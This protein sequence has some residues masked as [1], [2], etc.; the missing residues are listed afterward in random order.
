MVQEWN[1]GT[2]TFNRS[3]LI[4]LLLRVFVQIEF[5]ALH[6]RC[7]G[8]TTFITTLLYFGYKKNSNPNDPNQTIHDMRKRSQIPASHA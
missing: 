2:S 1:L 3:V 4:S 7:S 5:R 8:K 6:Y